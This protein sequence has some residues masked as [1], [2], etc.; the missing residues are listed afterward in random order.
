MA[1]DE[2]WSD[3]EL[4][5]TAQKYLW[6]LNQEKEGKP[7]V[8]SHVNRDVQEAIGRSKGSVEFRMRNISAVLHDLG[9]PWV[10]GY[11][12]AENVGDGVKARIRLALERA[13]FM[14]QS[15]YAPTSDDKEFDI[16]VAKLRRRRFVSPPVGQEK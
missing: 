8:K 6:M 3:Q 1:A 15:D 13:G 5:F 7:Y 11:F 10:K 12:P 9:Q 4:E 2:D 16:R 14:T